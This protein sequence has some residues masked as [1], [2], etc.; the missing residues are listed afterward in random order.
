MESVHLKAL[1]EHFIPSTTVLGVGNLQGVIESS[2]S[3]NQRIQAKERKWNCYFR[4]L[5]VQRS[6]VGSWWLVR[7][8][9]AI[10]DKQ[11][12]NKGQYSGNY[13]GVFKFS[14]LSFCSFSANLLPSAVWWQ[15]PQAY[16]VALILNF[17]NSSIMLPETLLIIS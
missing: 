4:S 8:D 10:R 13:S 1:V 16:N 5:Q 11:W 15:K 3:K 6:S 17:P 12:E 7:C 2:G 14:L 9:W